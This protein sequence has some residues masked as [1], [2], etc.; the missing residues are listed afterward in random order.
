MKKALM[1][2]I[3]FVA[4]ILPML[5]QASAGQDLRGTYRPATV[6]SVSKVDTTVDYAYDMGIRLDC[7][8]YVVR[9]KSANDYLPIGI[10]PDHPIDVLTGEHGY[11]MHLVLSPDHIAELRVMSTTGS[12][13]TSCANDLTR[14]PAAIPVGMILPVSLDSTMRSDKSRPGTAITATLTQD[15]P[16]SKGT[17]LRAGSKVTGRVVEARQPEKGSKEA[18]ISF[19]FDRVQL[20]N[21][22]VPVATNLR[23]LASVAAISATQVP[24]SGGDG[25]SPSSW[26][27]VQIGGD[28][29]SYGQGYPVMMGSEVVGKYTSQGVLAYAS[30][31]LGTECRSAIAGNT[32][33]QAFWVFSVHAC[34]AYG[35]GDMKIMHSG[36]TEPVGVVTLTSSGNAV[37]VGRSSGMLLRVDRSGAGETQAG[38]TAARVALH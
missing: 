19:Q 23:A 10:A 38:A 12:G 6:V 25:E 18:R 27:L 17:T 31:D 20:G 15:V 21:R 4:C 14:S 32:R 3:G 33:P 1:V 35:F 28:Q 13:E 8:L 34:G 22:M 16:L 11:W 30:Q 29:V 24:T 37:K 2:V 26:N 36:R 5:L 7:I 9:Y